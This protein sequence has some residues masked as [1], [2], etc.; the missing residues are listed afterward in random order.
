MSL[1]EKA[2]D[3]D[4][5]SRQGVSYPRKGAGAVIEENG[6]LLGYVHKLRQVSLSCER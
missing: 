4:F 6:E 3:V 2:I 5:L 1:V